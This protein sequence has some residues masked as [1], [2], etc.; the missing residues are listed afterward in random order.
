[1]QNSSLSGDAEFNLIPPSPR[2]AAIGS[3]DAADLPKI[4]NGRLEPYKMNKFRGSVYRWAGH[5]RG[6]TR[7]HA[8]T[9]HAQVQV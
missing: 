8:A 5:G 2:V 7:A 1:M 9:T 3:C 6:D 4:A